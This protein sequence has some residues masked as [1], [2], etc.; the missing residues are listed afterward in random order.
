MQEIRHEATN[1]NTIAYT[2][3]V[4]PALGAQYNFPDRSGAGEPLRSV[5][6][7]NRNALLD[8]EAFAQQ[9]KNN[10]SLSPQRQAEAIAP[11]RAALAEKVTRAQDILN[12]ERQKYEIDAAKLYAAPGPADAVEVIQDVELRTRLVGVGGAGLSDTFARLKGDQAAADRERILLALAR[13]PIPGPGQQFARAAWREKIER[14]NPSRVAALVSR[15]DD[16]DWAATALSQVASIA[17]ARDYPKG[18]ADPKLR[19]SV[20]PITTPART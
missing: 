17:Q 13:D 4:L 14:E 6:L 9:A 8:L 15:A 7:G 11:R 12:V 3:Y 19:G 10:K 16:L 2:Q 18:S 5:V 1:G 20:E